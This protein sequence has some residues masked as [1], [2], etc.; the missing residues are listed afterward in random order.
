MI[1]DTSRSVRGSLR[2]RTRGRYAPRPAGGADASGQ[3]R[4]SLTPRA[5]DCLGRARWQRYVGP[6]LSMTQLRI[7]A[8]AP[9]MHE[10]SRDSQRPPAMTRIAPRGRGEGG[11]G[12]ADPVD[13]ALEGVPRAAMVGGL[14]E[15]LDP[16]AMPW[17]PPR[18]C[19]CVLRQRLEGESTCLTLPSGASS[20]Y[21]SRTVTA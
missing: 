10:V 6:V 13:G 15:S 19:G 8:H 17:H 7:A 2:R 1:L 12:V 16:T 20:R 21:A 9:R 3:H 11:E 14:G 4:P 5:A 18:L